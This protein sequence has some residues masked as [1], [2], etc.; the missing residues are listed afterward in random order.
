M[1]KRYEILVELNQVQVD[2]RGEVKHRENINR[3]QILAVHSSVA[4]LAFELLRDAVQK[5]A[6]II[7]RVRAL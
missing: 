3:K 6:D 5:I 7:T 2:E 4:F 1:N